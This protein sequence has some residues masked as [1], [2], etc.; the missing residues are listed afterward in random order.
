MSSHNDLLSSN[1]LVI[2]VGNYV[3]P[4]GD[5]KVD[6]IPM[7]VVEDLHTEDDSV[8]VCSSK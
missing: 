5:I 7:E 4:F 8:R 2:S 1:E 3:N 6:D